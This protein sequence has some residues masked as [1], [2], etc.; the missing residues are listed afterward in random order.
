LLPNICLGLSMAVLFAMLVGAAMR[1]V[2]PH[3]YG[4]AGAGRTT[5]FQL[6]MSIGVAIGV[7]V[8]GRPLSGSAALHS[9]RINWLISGALLAVLS[10]V[11]ILLYPAR[12]EDRAGTD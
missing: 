1:D 3:R 4:M 10:G 6:A 12:V 5:V 9:Y 2:P 8:I 11:F 7:A